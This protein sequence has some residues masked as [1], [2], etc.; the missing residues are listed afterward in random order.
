MDDLTIEKV[1]NN[2]RHQLT[3][4]YVQQHY[5]TGNFIYSSQNPETSLGSVHFIEKGTESLGGY[6]TESTV[7]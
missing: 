7:K 2:K 6:I 3:I 5:C 4:Y 1:A